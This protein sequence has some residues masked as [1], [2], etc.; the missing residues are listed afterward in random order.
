M[1]N[2]K[3]DKLFILVIILLGITIGY[4]AL[5]STLKINGSTAVTK[6]TWNIYWDNIANQDGVTPTT[7][8]I[9]SE[10]ANHPNNIVT[11]SVT[12]DKPGDYYEFEVDAVN[13]G[14][15]DAEIID[16]EKKYNDTVI[17]ET[18]TS[19]LPS[20]LKYEVKY[21]DNTD[22]SVGDRLD[23]AED[24]T[25]NPPVYTIRTY[26]IRVE[27]DKDA[28]T[29]SDIN[30]QVGDVTH[31]FSFKVD[32]GQAT[33]APSAV[34]FA[35][36]PWDVI[37]S[38][39]NSAAL[40]ESTDGTCGVYNVGDTKSVDLGDLGVHT[41]RIA[42]CS[43]PV[44]CNTTG[45]S[46]TACGF[47]IEFTDI[48]SNHQMNP[49]CNEEYVGCRNTGGW[50]NSDM[51]AYLNN[52][53][54]SNNDP[55]NNE[56]ANYTSTGVLSNMP[57]D[58]KNLIANTTVVSAV[59]DENHP[60]KETTDKLYLLSTHEVWLD[61][62]ENEMGGIRHYDSSYYSTRQ[63]DYYVREGTETYYENATPAIKKYGEDDS[64]WSMRSTTLYPTNNS[65]FG[66]GS[67][68]L[69]QYSFTWNE[70]GVSPAF[71]LN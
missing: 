1:K 10:N 39:G 18:G 49:D 22:I 41:V 70:Q 23:K 60:T 37:A 59:S 3:R 35:T 61:V 52:G 68:G 13:A 43:T 6:N 32:Y 30:N 28:V 12:F 55:Y 64:S 66:V 48:I 40:Q 4:A 11:F 9:V 8:Q 56:T 33:P 45:F 16:I 2:K 14:T 65:F 34:A 27:Y 42:N 69:W 15:L 26:K 19:P 53:T 21:T 7:S 71:K 47:V 54:Y 62:N 44:E 63:L 51:R 24:L 46:Q 36:D 58:L 25:S 67:A 5:T 20:Y 38:E 57:N 50:E 17:P 31:E 29:N